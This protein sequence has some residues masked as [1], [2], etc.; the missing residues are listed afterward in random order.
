ADFQRAHL[1]EVDD[2]VRLDRPRQAPVEARGRLLGELAEGEDDAA[3]AL[4]DDVEAAREPDAD[5]HQQEQAGAAEGEAPAGRR[6]L[7]AATA[8]PPAEQLGEPAV[9]VA[10]ELVEIRR[11]LIAAA[12]ALRSARTA[13]ASPVR[14][15]QCQ[16]C[17]I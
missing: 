10:P 17:G 5:R 11:T 1:R 6:R 13:A 14:I 7:L 3:L 2:L 8:A 16:V 4:D 15:V 12:R 9:E